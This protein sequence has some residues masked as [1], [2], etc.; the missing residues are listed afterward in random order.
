[1][2]N[3]LSGL[4]IG[5]LLGGV[6]AFAGG[7]NHGRGAPIFSNPFVKHD[8]LSRLERQAEELLEETRR[9]LHEA[10]EE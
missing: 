4:I 3:F 2:P 7:Y 1:M 5:L 6:L 9:R 10:T 8:P